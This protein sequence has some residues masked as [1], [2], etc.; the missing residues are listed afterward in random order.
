MPPAWRKL[1]L[2]A[3]VAASVGWLGAVAAFLAVGLVG[4]TSDDAQTVRGAYLVM[5]PAA[6]IVLV[7]L[8]FASLATGLIQSFLTPWGVI[9]HYWVVF[10]LAITVFATIVLLLYLETFRSVADTAA[11]PGA[12]LASVQNVSPVLHAAGALVLLLA[13]T[14]LSEFKPRGLT[15]F[16][17]RHQRAQRLAERSGAD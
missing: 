12:E 11:D 5:E 9:R 1:A 13:A 14:V 6:K 4:L 2:T 7:P 3:H 17:R 8:A 16:G 15:L 10:K